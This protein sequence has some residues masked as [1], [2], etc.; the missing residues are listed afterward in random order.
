MATSKFSSR[1]CFRKERFTFEVCC[2]CFGGLV[3]WRQ[4]G[5]KTI[6]YHSHQRI[7]CSCI[8][9]KNV[10]IVPF[11]SLVYCYHIP[12]SSQL[13]VSEGCLHNPHLLQRYFTERVE[14]VWS[15][16]KRTSNRYLITETSDLNTI[17]SE[18]CTETA[19]KFITIRRY[20]ML[21]KFVF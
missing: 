14:L 8:A 1:G 19:A 5:L 12:G 6:W 4:P 15:L 20:L 10:D 21:V 9:G 3:G 13:A 18:H 16:R 2:C 17:S 7:S 11:T